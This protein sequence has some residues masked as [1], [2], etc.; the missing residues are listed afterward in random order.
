MSNEIK[1]KNFLNKNNIKVQSVKYS[2]VLGS[3]CY[4]IYTCKNYNINYLR[5]QLGNIGISR[6]PKLQ[7]QHGCVYVIEVED[8][9]KLLNDFNFLDALGESNY[10]ELIR[11]QLIINGTGSKKTKVRFARGKLVLLYNTKYSSTCI[12]KSLNICNDA[13][14]DVSAN[15]CGDL[16]MIV[17]LDRVNDPWVTEPIPEIKFCEN[18]FDLKRD[19]LDMANPFG[20]IRK[21][22]E[23]NCIDCGIIDMS[24]DDIIRLGVV[25]KNEDIAAALNIP[26]ESV[27]DMIDKKYILLDRVLK[28]VIPKC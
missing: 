1:L 9:H 7:G 10:A 19:A 17:L 6:I 13:V 23:K 15:D 2:N 8:G 22:L 28:K 20:C 26:K 14:V 24:T 27:V 3:D 16:K 18:E 5:K 25:A 4:L 12:A 21:Q 11:N